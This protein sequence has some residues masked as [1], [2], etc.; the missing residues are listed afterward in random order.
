MEPHTAFRSSLL[1]GAGGMGLMYLQGNGYILYFI[2]SFVYFLAE[3][4]LP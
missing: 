4:D 3:E 2:Y 1:P